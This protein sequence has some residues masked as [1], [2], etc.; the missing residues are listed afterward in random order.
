VFVGA[1]AVADYRP[2]HP[3]PQ[4]LKKHA[5]EMV[6][7]LVRN[8]DILAEVAASVPRPFVVGFAAETQDVE[9]NARLKLERKSLDLIAANKVGSDCGFDLDENSLV[10]LWDAGRE[11]LGSGTKAELADRLIGLIVER[12]RAGHQAQDS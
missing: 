6:V 1:A 7:E 3:A 10:V 12:M 9:A 2:A 4:K 8:P 5:G 11:D